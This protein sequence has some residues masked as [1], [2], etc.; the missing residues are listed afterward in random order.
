MH[1][2]DQNRGIIIKLIVNEDL[3]LIILLLLS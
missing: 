2:I 3:I 1:A